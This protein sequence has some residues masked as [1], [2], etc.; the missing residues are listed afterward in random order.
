ML[1]LVCVRRA[2]LAPLTPTRP[3]KPTGCP[4]NSAIPAAIKTNIHYYQT[5]APGSDA[6][7]SAT[8]MDCF[9]PRPAVRRQLQECAKFS[10]HDNF[11]NVEGNFTFL[12]QSCTQNC[13]SAACQEAYGIVR[14]NAGEFKEATPDV[15]RLCTLCNS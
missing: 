3:P 7:W 2:R 14:S 6:T 12:Q 13:S 11:E 9:Q 1:L 5:P 8:C 15:R 10:C 4:H